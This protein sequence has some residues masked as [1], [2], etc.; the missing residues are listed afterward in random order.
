MATPLRIQKYLS[1]L[2]ICSRREAE[3]WL[4][5]GRIRINGEVVTQLGT[6]IDPDRDQLS[7]DAP[8][9]AA[10]IRRYI[11]FHK[12]AGIVSNLPTAGERDIRSLLPKEYASVST[13]GRLDKDSEG[14]ILLTDDGVFAKQALNSQ[15]ER[16][17]VVTVSGHFSGGMAERLEEGVQIFGEKTRRTKIE[18][19]DSNRFIIHMNEGKNRQIRR[20]ITKVGLS[21]IRLI[22]TK[23]GPIRLGHLEPG[24]YRELAPYEIEAIRNNR[25]QSGRPASKPQ[26]RRY[27]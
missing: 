27:R 11:A 26:G 19:L 23:Y 12:P 15:H 8:E 7:I 16:E 21:V 1:E 22:R 20:M 9:K 4:L 14:V 3:R 10:P 2:N 5:E 25:P 6:M 18:I 13:I 24:R 17:Y